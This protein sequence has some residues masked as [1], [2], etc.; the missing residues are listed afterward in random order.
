M[1]VALRRVAGGR[2]VNGDSAGA[3]HDSADAS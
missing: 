1:S 3:R 2:P